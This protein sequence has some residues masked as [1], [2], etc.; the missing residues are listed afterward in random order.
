MVKIYT[1]SKIT[2]WKWI[3]QHG[4]GVYKTML[5]EKSQGTNQCAL[6]LVKINA[7]RCTHTWKSERKRASALIILSGWGGLGWFYFLLYIFLN[8]L[9]F[10]LLGCVWVMIPWVTRGKKYPT[11]ISLKSK[12]ISLSAVAE[13]QSGLPPGAVGGP[14]WTAWEQ[15]FPKRSQGT[16]L[17]KAAWLL[18]GKITKC[19]WQ[20]VLLL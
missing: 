7:C 9:N 5:T 19:L 6:Y 12:G 4:R 8:S 18:D 13:E 11:Q 3:Q 2:A 14:T 16:D 10:S 15:W 20:H 17:Q 1:F